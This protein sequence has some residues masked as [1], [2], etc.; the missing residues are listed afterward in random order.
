MKS[1]EGRARELMQSDPDGIRSLARDG[2]SQ[3]GR[4]MR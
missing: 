2:I 1:F 4:F 3:A